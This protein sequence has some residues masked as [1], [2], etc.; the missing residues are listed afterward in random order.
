V[1]L[2]TASRRPIRTSAAA[3]R[4]DLHPRAEHRADQLRH[5]TRVMLKPRAARRTR[6]IGYRRCRISYTT[7]VRSSP[8]AV[9]VVALLSACGDGQQTAAPDLSSPAVDDFAVS[10]DLSVS[11]LYNDD[12]FPRQCGYAPDSSPP[13]P[14]VSGFCAGTSIAG[15]CAQT[16]FR[17]IAECF[18][19]SGCCVRA[20]NSMPRL[21]WASGAFALYDG[22]FGYVAV[23]QDGVVCGETNFDGYPLLKWKAWDGTRLTFDPNTGI[24]T[25]DDGTT[26]SLGVGYAACP[27]IVTMLYPGTP[28]PIDHTGDAAAACCT[29][30]PI[31]WLPPL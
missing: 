24:A 3:Q 30:Y 31:D 26:I 18:A 9:F 5:R 16:F 19:P 4:D 23:I 13:K 25:C 14:D 10:A 12:M 1:D 27:E 6:S 17:T 22:S 21:T 29:P 2:V 15:T 11:I 20:G 8:A 7:K 28:C